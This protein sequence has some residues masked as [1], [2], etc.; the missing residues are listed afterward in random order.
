[1]SRQL[2][3]AEIRLTNT[4]AC[5]TPAVPLLN[6]LSDAFGTPFMPAISN[7]ILS[8]ITAVQNVKKN[9]EDC[10]KLLENVYQLLCGII[11][12]HLKSEAKGNLPPATL[13]HVGKFTD[14][15]TL[16]KV[17]AFV[18]AQQD[19]NKI[20]SFFRQTET[21]TLLSECRMGLQQALEAFKFETNTT[22]LGH[23]AQMKE[24]A[25]IMHKETYKTS[26]SLNSS[27]SIS[28]L[29][30]KPKIFHGR[31][32]ELKEIVGILHE[33]SPRIAI[34][35]PGGMGK[36]SLAKATLHHPDIASKYEQ[37]FFVLAD[38]V[39]TS[40]GLSVL[41]A[42]HI[43]LKPAKDVTTQVLH[44]FSTYGPSLLILDNLETSWEPLESRGEITMRGAERPAK[45]QWTRPF[46][47]PLKPLSH[48]AAQDTFFAIAEDMHDS[49][50]VDEVLS[51]T[52]NMPLAVDLI[53]H[54]VDLEGSCSAV[55][56]RWK[57]EKTSLLSAGNDRKSNLD[58]SITISLSSSRMSPGAKDLLS[59]LSILPDGLSDVDLLQS[60]L[61][62]NDIMTCRATLLATS[63]AYV[64]DKRQLKLL[65]P[66]RE[67]MQCFYPP[68]PHLIHPLQ[69]YF[70]QLLDLFQQYPRTQQ[71]AG[72]VKHIAL[73]VKNMSELL[74]RGLNQ[75]N[76]NL[77][78]T[79]DCTLSMK[80]FIQN[81]DLGY[82]HLI[83]M[84]MEQME[85]VLP[86]NCDEKVKAQLMTWKFQS[87][88][89]TLSTDAEL[90]ITQAISHFHQLNDPAL[91]CRFYIQ[92][93]LYYYYAESKP[94]VALKYLHKAL[95]LAK[96][97]GDRRQEALVLNHLGQ[98]KWLIGD[99]GAGQKHAQGS[100]RVAELAG[101]L[102]SQAKALRTS[103]LCYKSCGDTQNSIF[104]RQRARK[105]LELCGITT[106]SLYTNI[107]Q[108]LADAQFLK[109][110]YAEARN[111]HKQFA[112]DAAAQEPHYYAWAL[113]NIAQLDI[114]IGASKQDVLS[115]LEKAMALLDAHR[116][117]YYDVMTA[118]IYC[119]I[120]LGQLHLRE[121]EILTAK[122]ILQTCFE[123]TWGNDTQG[124]LSCMECFANICHWPE[125]DFN[126]AASWTVVYLGYA[127][128]L[129]DKIALHRAL[130][131]LGD[132]FQT[133][134]DHATSTSL[135]TVALEGF[136]WMDIHCSRAECM[137]R[138]GDLGKG[139]G[140][141]L[142]AIELW[143]TA[144]P[145]FERSSQGKQVIQID[146]RLAAITN[147][148]LEEPTDSLTHLGQLNAP[149]TGEAAPTSNSSSI[150]GLEPEGPPLTPCRGHTDSRSSLVSY[151]D[152][153]PKSRPL[154]RRD[155]VA[156]S[157]TRSKKFRTICIVQR[158]PGCFVPRFQLQGRCGPFATA[159]KYRK[160]EGDNELR[161]PTEAFIR[162]AQDAKTSRS[163]GAKVRISQCGFPSLDFYLTRKLMPPAS[164]PSETSPQLW[165]AFTAKVREAPLI[166][167]FDSNNVQ[168]F[169]STIFH[170]SRP[171]VKEPD[172]NIYFA[173]R[174]S[175]L[176]PL[177]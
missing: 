173:Y 132:V 27:S 134:G 73:N 70:H 143:K 166:L 44:Y 114:I 146:E 61:S 130:Q 49:Q 84:L 82:Y 69:K 102:H 103:A 31:E 15:V 81:T 5:L 57:S 111:I 96:L 104:L 66:I 56:A 89:P 83:P 155:T 9:K 176:T 8:L 59:L 18:E 40:I 105:L 123:S 171:P 2:S 62:I 11:N 78:D 142:K 17:H 35:G 107:L 118:K 145:L 23:M 163:R 157:Y 119:N 16:H 106:G 26:G 12:L 71:G 87:R 101:D 58:T 88:S 109:S 1:M 97:C 24:E 94:S 162:K 28:M 19:G 25:E 172:P 135:F 121:G 152:R 140:D 159:R 165:L 174:Y 39:M 21:K 48:V 13:K 6:Q 92:V 55:L 98:I 63:L 32:S 65:V 139:H 76:P 177:P 113:L 77:A 112:R 75:D 3:V 52:D 154:T 7:T 74:L 100:H 53:A 120:V 161:S 4:I 29:P 136:T 86:G 175:A 144:R 34:L 158:T 137:L 43:G 99:Y 47:A 36:T 141:V 124:A 50:D 93:G 151:A 122:G 167:G 41:I 79:I 108:D 160:E 150:R 33:E 14:Y 67:H 149:I 64:D 164:A 38:S 138:L 147:N 54:A 46:L 129:G 131:F 22:A 51:L 148:V 72:R 85:A 30:A 37:C 90:L 68:S 156:N 169:S 91:E 128:K 95:D 45:V 115:N 42:E 153:A 125:H 126:W 110:E 80:L 170:L 60:K 20:K 127:N 117:G 133:E 168:G 116:Y 10:I